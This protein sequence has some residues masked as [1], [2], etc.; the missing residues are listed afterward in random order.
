MRKLLEST[1]SLIIAEAQRIG[2]HVD[3]EVLSWPGGCIIAVSVY[4]YARAVVFTR[5]Y[6]ER[7]SGR[8]WGACEDHRVAPLRKDSR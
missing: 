3:P 5:G 1:A 2:V 4:L 8:T 6:I 7:R